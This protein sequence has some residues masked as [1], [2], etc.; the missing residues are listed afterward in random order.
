MAYTHTIIIPLYG[1]YPEDLPERILSYLDNRISVI[2][3]EN[4]PGFAGIF[5]PNLEA[6]IKIKK[7]IHTIVNRNQGGLAGGLNR[8]IEKAIQNGAFWVTLLDQD[9]QLSANEVNRLVEPWEVMPNQLILVGPMIWDNDRRHMHSNK[10]T[11]YSD[12]FRR[13]RL[14]IS[15]GT[16]FKASDWERLGQ[17][18]EWLIV[19]FI[20]HAWSFQAQQR[21]FLLLHHPGVILHQYFGQKHPNQVCHLLG[22]QLYSPMRHFYSLR[23]L[24]WLIQQRNVPL[25]LKV[26]EISKMLVKTWLWLLCESK[27]KENLRAIIKAL[28]T[29]IPP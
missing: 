18:N 26:K 20:D 28:T 12:G 27:R 29:P 3:V 13:T 11:E 15:S 1:Q 10:M 7:G 22:M 9:S 14:L 24:R 6:I 17:M 4:N 5:S 8:G 16:T 23:N 2:L 25:D 21:G 19:D